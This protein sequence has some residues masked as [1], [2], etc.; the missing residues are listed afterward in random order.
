MDSDQEIPLAPMVIVLRVVGC[1][2][3][4]AA[5]V[6]A[7]TTNMPDE[8]SIGLLLSSFI[9]TLFFFTAGSIVRLLDR[10]E[11]HLARSRSIS[12]V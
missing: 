5:F 1:I 2:L 8:L 9:G 12:T 7:G 10:I 4:L 3:P 11:K 6:F